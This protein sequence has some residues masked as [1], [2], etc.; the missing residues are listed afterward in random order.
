MLR[1]TREEFT[2]ARERGKIIPVRRRVPADLETPVSA[3][4]KLRNLPE[5]Q[6]AR[7]LLESVERGI[8]VG[9]Y[10]FI[11]VS[12]A[13]TLR[14]DGDRVHIVRADGETTIA[15]RKRAALPAP[16]S[17]PSFRKERRRSIARR[18]PRWI[19]PSS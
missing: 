15:L 14:L 12:P 13:S 4:L 6:R 10:S 8:Q 7:F 16:I 9:R 2:A 18:S 11:G 19:R 17:S 3:F 1:P 5:G